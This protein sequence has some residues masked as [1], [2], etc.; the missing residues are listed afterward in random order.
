MRYY[1]VLFTF[2]ISFIS[3]SFSG[4]Y[5]PPTE[6]LGGTELNGNGCVCHSLDRDYDVMVWVEGPDT[7]MSGQTGLYKMF[8][9]GGPAEAGGYNVAGRYG[10]MNTVDSLS[11]WDYRTPNELIQAFPLEFASTSDTIFWPFEY[12]STDSSETDTIYS[13]GL[14]IVYDHIPDSLDRWNFGSKFPIIVID[15]VV[16]VELVS[17]TALKNDNS[18]LLSWMTAS[19]INNSGFEIQRFQDYPNGFLQDEI[20]RINDWQIVG[21]VDGMGTT[22]EYSNY[23]FIDEGLTSGRY[24][25]RL[26]QIDFDGTFT[27][28]DEVQIDLESPVQFILEQN[29]PNPFNPKT[30]ISWQSSVSSQQTLKIYDMLGN[31]IATLVNEF[32]EAGKYEV[33]FNAEL[34]PSGVYYYQL[35]TGDLSETKKMVLLK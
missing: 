5:N 22:T 30:K 35:K 16:P 2:F 6:I 32:M 11:N 28:S 25:Y 19:E 33:E 21:F 34:L 4:F 10:V 3:L 29:Y 24:A 8:M 9:A 12:T 17:F 7:L 14:S 20:N 31:E 13:V 27:Y 26:K 23:S 15:E 1:L 18:V